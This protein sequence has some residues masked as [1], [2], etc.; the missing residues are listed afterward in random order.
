MKS[1]RF[2][3]ETGPGRLRAGCHDP[4]IAHRG[5]EAWRSGVS[6]ERRHSMELET[7]ALC[8]D[9]ATKRRFTESLGGGF[10]LSRFPLFRSP[11]FP[12]LALVVLPLL[13]GY[14]QAPS[15]PGSE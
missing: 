6:A 10:P 5:H 14:S 11:L 9:A 13:A 12:T 15:G 7:A 2:F 8:R 1:A 4:Q 3:A